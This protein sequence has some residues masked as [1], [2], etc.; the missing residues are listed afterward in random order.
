MDSNDAVIQAFDADMEHYLKVNTEVLTDNNTWSPPLE[1]VAQSQSQPYPINELPESILSAVNEVLD[2]TQCP[3]A[4]AACCALSAI[5][6]AT[7]HLANVKRDNGLISPVS[8]YTLAIAES[9][10]RKTSVDKHFISAIENWQKLQAE[11]AKPELTR[12]WVESEAW[13]MQFDGLKQKIKETAKSQKPVDALKLQ[14]NDL[15][16][17]EP[18]KP[19]VPRLIYNDVTP[20]QLAYSLSKS[21]PSAGVLSSEAGIVFGS[22]GMTG[23]STMRNLSQL[24]T[25]WDGGTLSID[26]RTS[27]SYN[28]SGARLTMGLAVQADTIKN[29][30][31]NSKQL[32]RGTGFAA[33]FLI[34]YPNSTQGTRFY[35][36]PPKDWKALTTFNNRITDLLNAQANIDENGGLILKELDFTPEAKKSWVMFYNEIERALGMDGELTNIRDVASKAADNVSRLAALFHLFEYSDSNSINADLVERACAIVT[37]HLFEAR[38]FLDEV[39]IPTNISNAIKTDDYIL[40]YCRKYNLNSI[41]K[42]FLRQHG[43]VRINSK[44]LDEALG[45]LVDAN[46]IRIILDDRTSIIEVNPALLEVNHA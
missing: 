43:A 46:R 34:A 37:W 26:R 28:V 20:E 7:Q 9:G 29:F 1:L 2:F 30:F 27:E 16:A 31:A 41:T 21:Y 38:R 3:S 36:D 8:I 10:E 11:L 33:R 18:V 44:T 40:R 45:E 32:A 24:N 19:K 12:Y 13:T 4:L 6:L 25:L 15:K 42:T 17:N 23:D 22:H 35:K 5:S 39:V 14:L